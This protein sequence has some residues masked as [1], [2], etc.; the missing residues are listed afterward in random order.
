[1]DIMEE[2]EREIDDIVLEDN[3]ESIVGISRGPRGVSPPKV[4]THAS[5]ANDSLAGHTSAI[6][7]DSFLVLEQTSRNSSDIGGLDRPDGLA[8][9][10]GSPEDEISGSLETPKH[11]SGFE[12]KAV[13]LGFMSDHDDP[14]DTIGESFLGHTGDPGQALQVQDNVA[15]EKD[16]APAESEVNNTVCKV[17]ASI[18][19]E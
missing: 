8:H 1:M 3:V 17:G 19:D 7:H 14:V 12:N 9:T 5:H 15:Q 13:P 2:I 10:T 6:G 16:G 18:V 11:V 4:T